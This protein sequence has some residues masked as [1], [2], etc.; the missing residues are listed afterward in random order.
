MLIAIEDY[1]EDPGVTE[2]KLVEPCPY[3]GCHRILVALLN[4]LD[5]YPS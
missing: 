1:I 4:F 3:N 5:D 2:A